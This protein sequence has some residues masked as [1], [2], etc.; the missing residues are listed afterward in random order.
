MILKRVDLFSVP[1]DSENRDVFVGT[2]AAYS[3]FLNN[4]FKIGEYPATDNGKGFGTPVNITDEGTTIVLKFTF[5]AESSKKVEEPF[6]ANYARLV[7][8]EDEELYFFITETQ[9]LNNIVEEKEIGTD[10]RYVLTEMSVKYSL[11]FD[12]F[13]NYLDEIITP[14]QRQFLRRCHI[15]QYHAED[16]PRLVSDL[17]SPQFPVKP[18][19]GEISMPTVFED[20]FDILFAV[21][22]FPKGDNSTLETDQSL[23]I[24]YLT[25]NSGNYIYGSDSMEYYFV[26]VK[27]YYRGTNFPVDISDLSLVDL[28]GTTV[29]WKQFLSPDYYPDAKGDGNLA[30]VKYTFTPPFKWHFEETD[31]KIV[32]HAYSNRSVHLFGDGSNLNFTSFVAPSGTG[33]ML[34]AID[35]SNP[36]FNGAFKLYEDLQPLLDLMSVD[37]P[38][39]YPSPSIVIDPLSIIPYN[40]VLRRNPFSHVEVKIGTD[41]WKPLDTKYLDDVSV[42]LWYNPSIDGCKYYITISKNGTQI[43]NGFSNVTF[44][45]GG[46]QLPCSVDTYDAYMRNH[47]QSF[48]TQKTVNS[49]KYYAASA[50]NSS[51]ILTNPL[52]A[53]QS[54]L[55]TEVSLQTQRMMLDSFEDD[56][57]NAVDTVQNLSGGNIDDLYID[58]PTFRFCVF[59]R[60]TNFNV[61]V[62]YIRQAM[63]FGYEYNEYG[64]PFERVT[65][66]YKYIETVNSKMVSIKNLKHR[67]EVEEKMN[68][69]LT[70]WYIS[71]YNETSVESVKNYFKNLNKDIVNVPMPAI[72]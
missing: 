10:I 27:A 6:N 66:F 57:L 63:Y 37:Y 40:P 48:A 2:S 58:R 33:N 62:E 15:K 24:T 29:S 14:Q 70:L 26:P 23:Q 53:S 49:I 34:C 9:E 60:T 25:W 45:D 50:I 51:N 54:Q 22:I 41:A 69:G 72:R 68:R 38:S 16:P 64:L 47:G 56:L 19:I 39:E 59:D 61:N 71:G 5:P 17:Q 55:N 7:S 46:L 20:K 65:W 36:E 28:A 13:G 18:Y 30:G 4:N 1:F 67:R 3:T 44:A 42:R 11:K 12:V 32:L 35:R 52:K 8:F 43:V 21:Y 31:L